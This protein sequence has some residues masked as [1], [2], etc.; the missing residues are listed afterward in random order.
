MTILS[1]KRFPVADEKETQVQIAALLMDCTEITSYSKEKKLDAKNII[2]FFIEGI[3]VEVKIKGSKKAIYR[4]CVRYCEF[5]E[6]TSLVLVTSV[7]IGFPS[8]IN[9]K[10]CYVLNM[11]KAWL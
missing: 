1:G 10:P 2:D 9:G 4:Q 6:I 11:S 5:P 8:E 7:S 3:G